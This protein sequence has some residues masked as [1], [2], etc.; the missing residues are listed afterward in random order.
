MQQVLQLV[1]RATKESLVVHSARSVK[2]V[3]QEPFKTKTQTQVPLAKRVQRGT[4]TPRP[5]KV[6][7]KTWALKK[8]PTATNFNTS[9]TPPPTQQIGHASNAPLVLPVMATSIGTVSRP[10]LGG[11][12]ATT[13]MPLLNVVLSPRPAWAA[14]TP[15]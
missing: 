4:T 2:I 8:R 5:E 7:A 10:N 11:P 9:M 1:N 14:P 12:D 3:Q 13:M 15:H 6:R